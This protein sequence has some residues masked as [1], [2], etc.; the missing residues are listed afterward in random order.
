MK[1]NVFLNYAFISINY[2]IVISVNWLKIADNA[3]S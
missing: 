2:I 1:G 3:L